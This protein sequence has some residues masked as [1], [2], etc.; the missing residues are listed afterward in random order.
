MLHRLTLLCLMLMTSTLA[1]AEAKLTFTKTTHDFG[2]I[3]EE[4]GDVTVEFPFQN[5]GDSPLLILRATSSCGCTVPNYPKQPV[6]PGQT[7][8]IT[9]TYHA[10]GRPGPFQK[11]VHVYDNTNGK[12]MISIA[13]NVVSNAKP[14]DTYAT[15]MGAGLRVKNRTL[16]FFDVYPNRTNRTR[17]L[18]FYNDSDEPMQLTFRNLP[19]DIYVECEP[20]IIQPKKE[21][22]VLVTFLTD[23]AKDWGIRRET[24]EVFVR[25]KESKAKNNQINIQADIWED[26]SNMSAKE[27]QQAP[28]IE[29]EKTTLDFGAASGNVT[30]E[31]VIRNTGKSKL[32]IRKISNELPKAFQ[33]NLSDESIKPG[34]TAK[35]K[36]TFC[37]AECKQQTI[38]H[39]LTIICNDPSNS[40]VI[41][42]LQATK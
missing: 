39:H 1:W 32:Q 28:E 40:R 12:T 30:Q 5:T 16:N 19:K 7:G 36:V 13:G 15:E 21:G 41:I 38:S 37:P 22:K 31:I 35:L 9:V 10:Q 11:S 33:T 17:T 8:V 26:F 42:N 2:T 18:Q 24:F 4:D 20:Q 3:Q 6:R 23:K 29:I 25:G 27:R 34:E 14:E